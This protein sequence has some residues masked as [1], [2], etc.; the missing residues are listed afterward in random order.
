MCNGIAFQLALCPSQ[1]ASEKFADPSKELLSCLPL[2]LQGL[3]GTAEARTWLVP[4]MRMHV[5]GARLAFWFQTMLPLARALE[6][7]AAI[8]AK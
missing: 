6:H 1:S 8:A 4:L 3:D 2:F 7:R 5:R